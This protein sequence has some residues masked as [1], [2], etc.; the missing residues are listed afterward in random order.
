[1]QNPAVSA[2]SIS[3]GELLLRIDNRIGSVATGTVLEIANDHVAGLA[4]N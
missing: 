2:R 3:G 1:M 4:E